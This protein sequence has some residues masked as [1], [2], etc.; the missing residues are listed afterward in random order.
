MIHKLKIKHEYLM[1][2]DSGIKTFEVRKNDRNYQLGDILNLNSIDELGLK[3]SM[4]VK[5]VYIL[6]DSNYTKDDYVIL[7]IEVIWKQII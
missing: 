2:I 1:D 7:G 4:D 6:D 5:V 3:F